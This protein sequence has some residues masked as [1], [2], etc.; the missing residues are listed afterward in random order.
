MEVV[1]SGYDVYDG[2][3]RSCAWGDF[4]EGCEGRVRVPRTRREALLDEFERSGGSAAQ[5]A[6]YVGLRYSTFANWVNNRRRQRSDQQ[7]TQ[8]S[9]ESVKR[10]EGVGAVRWFEA[11]VESGGNAVRNQATLRVYLPGGAH[12]EVANVQQSVLAA[13]LLQ[14]LGRLG[15]KGC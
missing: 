7:L 15:A 11:V 12:L 10:R 14:N 2:R 8:G 5:F 4:Q 3:D 6:A 9:A 13:E 1:G